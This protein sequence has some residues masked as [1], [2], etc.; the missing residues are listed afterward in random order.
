MGS[1]WHQWTCS[2]CKEIQDCDDPGTTCDKCCINFCE[3]CATDLDNVCDICM[4]HL[5]D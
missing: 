4:E 3:E 2:N 5:R 1:S